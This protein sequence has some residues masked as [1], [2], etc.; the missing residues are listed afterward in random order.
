MA[1]SG[2]DRGKF[3][4][5]RWRISEFVIWMNVLLRGQKEESVGNVVDIMAE[6]GNLALDYRCTR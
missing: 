3:L 5:E 1:T 6:R 4:D 2:R